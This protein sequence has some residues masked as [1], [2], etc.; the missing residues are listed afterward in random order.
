[1]SIT[2][3]TF[4]VLII[5]ACVPMVLFFL[6]GIPFLVADI[7]DKVSSG[8]FL[9]NL[10]DLLISSSGWALIA[11]FMVGP[12]SVGHVFLLG[13]PLFLVGWQFR[14][15]R[16]WTT[17]PLSFIIGAVPSV[18]FWVFYLTLR[19]NEGFFLL[20]EN[21]NS[22]NLVITISLAIIMG[23]F[24]FSGGLAF[25]FLWRYW[26]SPDSPHGRPFSEL[27]EVEIKPLSDNE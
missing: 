24:G 7:F 9:A 3:K 11:I 2:L 21:M 5:T 18:L 19:W 8:T 15:I 16:W 14:A 26:A 4:I 20:T 22:S 12:F 1:M 13:L 25:W 23:G 10:N 27:P 6:I 17:L